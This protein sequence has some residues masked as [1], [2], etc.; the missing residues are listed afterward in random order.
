MKHSCKY[1]GKRVTVARFR[2]GYDYCTENLC[3]GKGLK[4]FPVVE[5]SGYLPGRISTSRVFHVAAKE[6]A[7]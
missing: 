3:V 1:C 6:I 4:N 5:C 2:L 7:I